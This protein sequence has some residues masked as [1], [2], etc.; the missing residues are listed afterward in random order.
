MSASWSSAR[1][2]GDHKARDARG[3]HEPRQ[4]TPGRPWPRRNRPRG[5]RFDGRRGSVIAVFELFVPFPFFILPLDRLRFTGQAL[6]GS[7]PSGGTLSFGATWEGFRIDAV[8]LIGPTPIMFDH[9]IDD[10]A[11][12]ALLRSS[13]QHPAKSSMPVG[14]FW[15]RERLRISSERAYVTTARNAGR[16]P[17]PTHDGL[18][19]TLGVLPAPWRRPLRSSCLFLVAALATSTPLQLVQA[20]TSAPHA[21]GKKKAVREPKRQIGTFGIS[22]SLNAP[23]TDFTNVTPQTGEDSEPHGRSG[24]VV[25]PSVDSNGNPVMGLGF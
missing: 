8:E 17:A 23:S 15:V 10:V 13:A 7:D 14:A 20:Q 18:V 25:R 12:Q 9:P 4:R 5:K 11:H 1:R 21:I 24:P 19:E 22:N 3:E 6:L 2:E 16:R